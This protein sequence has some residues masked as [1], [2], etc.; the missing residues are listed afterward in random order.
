M[1]AFSA[2]LFSWRQQCSVAVPLRAAGRGR[3]ASLPDSDCSSNQGD[4]GGHPGGD[5]LGSGLLDLLEA[6]SAAGGQALCR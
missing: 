6:Y 3:L 2:V 5:C 4:P 1:H